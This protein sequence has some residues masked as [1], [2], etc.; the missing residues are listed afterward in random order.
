MSF[1]LML[2]TMYAQDVNIGQKVVSF[3]YGCIRFSPI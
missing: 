2:F 1:L 3:C